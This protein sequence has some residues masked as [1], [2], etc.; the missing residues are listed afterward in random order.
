MLCVIAVILFPFLFLVV[1]YSIITLIYF[2]TIM[3]NV[4]KDISRSTAKDDFAV[5]RVTTRN[6]EGA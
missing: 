2:W 4:W 3:L 1:C 5:K 6:V